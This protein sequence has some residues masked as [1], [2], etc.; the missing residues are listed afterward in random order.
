MGAKMVR[1]YGNDPRF[2][3]KKFL[4][5]AN[6]W[7]LKVVAGISDYP[8]E[9]GPGKC[10]KNDLNCYEAIRESYSATLENKSFV[11][12]GKYHP[13]LD[14]LVL[15]NE[16]DLKFFGVP[17]R[18]YM[19]AVLSAFD[20]VLAA[21]KAKGLDV[22]SPDNIKFTAAFSYQVCPKCNH[23]LELRSLGCCIDCANT[24]GTLGQVG[25]TQEDGGMRCPRV[26]K[27]FHADDCPGLPMIVDLHKAMEDPSSV[28]YSFQT[29]GWEQAFANRWI[30]SFNGFVGADALDQQFIQ[31]YSKLPFNTN[32]PVD[33]MIKVFMGEYGDPNLA[34]NPDLLKV[35][36]EKAR[37]LVEDKTNAFV[38]F[39]FFQYQVAYWKPCED[40]AGW[41]RW[42]GEAWDNPMGKPVPRGCNE[43][44][45][46]TF[47]LGDIQVSKTGGINYDSH[48]VY[49]I[50]CVKPI[51]RGKPEAIAAAYGGSAPNTAICEA[52]WEATPKQYC[53]AS[54][55]DIDP[56]GAGLG[57]VCDHLGQMGHDCTEGLPAAC[58]DDIY[59]KSD[60]AFSMYFELKKGE[61]DA[62]SICD[63]NGAGVVTALPGRLD[64][65]AVKTLAS[66]T[67]TAAAPTTTADPG[68]PKNSSGLADKLW[69]FLAAAALVLGIIIFVR[70]RTG[71]PNDSRSS[72]T[73]Q[74]ASDTHQEFEMT[75]STLR[76]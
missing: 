72:R 34:R 62:A 15:T 9:H 57:W 45:Y 25:K 1:L 58:A 24:C 11:A 2:D 61:A 42:E 39:N 19:K 16:P 7:G 17:G 33:K 40:S 60:W 52:G 27:P 56:L 55:G 73:V 69:W 46:G 47:S 28:G 12:H 66:T 75:T 36:L 64:C 51:F 35:D 13:A 29:E 44:L 50:Q 65:M 6:R 37:K 63:F 14:T 43:R 32:K 23:I 54:R 48:N 53:V 5:Y 68:R 4:D 74:R 38:G 59:T 18:N 49:P 67:S 30:H 22:T 41:D 21:E 10:W 20:G 8:Y 3:G 70:S 71:E 31:K 26:R 76:A